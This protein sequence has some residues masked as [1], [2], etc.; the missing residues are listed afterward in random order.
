MS[1]DSRSARRLL[2]RLFGLGLIA[3]LV[4]FFPSMRAASAQVQHDASPT[5]ASVAYHLTALFTGGARAGKTLE[6]A[7]AGTLDSTGVLTAT[8]TMWSGATSAITGTLS[9]AG[10][11]AT[12]TVSGKALTAALTGTASGK[13]GAFAGSMSQAGSSSAGSWLLVPE[14][15]AHQYSFNAT[16]SRGKGV[17][18]VIGG[19]IATSAPADP[20]AAFDAAVSLDDGNGGYTTVPGYGWWSRGNLH[21]VFS[22]PTGETF[23]GIATSSMKKLR[24]SAPFTYLS[25][26]FVGPAAGDSGTWYAAQG[27]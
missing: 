23:V 6:G 2:H 9:T 3:C 8:I 24:G 13:A 10:S 20:T 15:V 5:S 7:V 14:T 27:S 21:I 16:I 4:G 19:S 26:W 17:G 12:L 25:G 11:G 22:L 1:P 18:T